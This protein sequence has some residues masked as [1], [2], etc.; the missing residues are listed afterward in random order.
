VLEF[1]VMT[2]R[3]IAGVRILDGTGREPFTGSVRVVGNR[4]AEVSRCADYGDLHRAP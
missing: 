3:V 1:A 2:S 4:I